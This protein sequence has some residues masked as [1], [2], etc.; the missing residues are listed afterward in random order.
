MH[1]EKEA[2]EERERDQISFRERL[3]K[4]ALLGETTKVNTSG[5]FTSFKP[6]TL[7]HLPQES[8]NDTLQT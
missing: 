4:R 2:G 8:F 1:L 6:C 7:T 5:T 3:C